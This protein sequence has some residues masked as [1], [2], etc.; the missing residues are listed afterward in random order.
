MTN[1][2]GVVVPPSSAQ[3]IN[4]KTKKQTSGLRP[5]PRPPSTEIYA[6]ATL[7]ISFS[8]RLLQS[9]TTVSLPVALQAPFS[10]LLRVLTIAPITKRNRR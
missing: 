6:G 10:L 2:G 7:T 9:N 4:T 3:F 8:Y 1:K 5:E